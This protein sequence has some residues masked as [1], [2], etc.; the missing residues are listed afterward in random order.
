MTDIET[1]QRLGCDF[2]PGPWCWWFDTKAGKWALVTEFTNQ[3]VRMGGW[4]DSPLTPDQRLTVASPEL[5]A[6]CLEAERTLST[7]INHGDMTLESASE[8][9]S[10]LRMAMSRVVPWCDDCG[11]IATS[12]EC[13]LLVCPF[14]ESVPC[15]C[16][17]D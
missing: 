1:L 15:E 13:G 11:L 3:R 2:T 9:R 7:W 17:D 14:C 16:D 5:Y 4:P 12:C 6:A 8:A 10:T